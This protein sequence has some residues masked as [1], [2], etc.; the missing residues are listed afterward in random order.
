MQEGS[1]PRAAEA[2]SCGATAV[3]LRDLPSEAREAWVAEPFTKLH[4][5]A[6]ILLLLAKRPP[7]GRVQ[8]FPKAA[9]GRK[10]GT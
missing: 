6:T 8:L 5:R 3:L 10:W 1:S 2:G 4:S 9:F 7:S